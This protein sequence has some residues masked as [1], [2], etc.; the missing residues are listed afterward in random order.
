[1]PWN[2]KY[3]RSNCFIDF[4]PHKDYPD[5]ADAAGISAEGFGNSLGHTDDPLGDPGQYWNLGI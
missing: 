1:M 3:I 4:D 5:L 2:I